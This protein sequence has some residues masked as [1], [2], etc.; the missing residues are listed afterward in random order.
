MLELWLRFSCL[1]RF[2][3]YRVDLYHHSLSVV[4]DAKSLARLVT[5]YPGFHGIRNFREARG[6]E[7]ALVSG[8]DKQE[9]FDFR[10]TF[11]ATYPARDC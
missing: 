3:S 4:F 1:D 10:A 2:R 11:F 5:A 8:V 6:A 7:R 9:H